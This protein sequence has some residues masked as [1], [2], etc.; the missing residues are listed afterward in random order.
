MYQFG[1]GVESKLIDIRGLFT[2]LTHM[3]PDV[4]QTTAKK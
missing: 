1:V 3:L 2:T 4:T